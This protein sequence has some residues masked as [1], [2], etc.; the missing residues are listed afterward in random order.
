MSPE[1]DSRSHLASNPQHQQLRRVIPS[2]A[3]HPLCDASCI[4]S[5][6]GQAFTR[7]SPDMSLLRQFNP[8]STREAFEPG[9][10]HLW[11]RTH[12]NLLLKC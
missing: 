5:G 1:P 9:L 2:P 10:I 4:P 3:S 12:T 7:E 6:N 8:G 11:Y